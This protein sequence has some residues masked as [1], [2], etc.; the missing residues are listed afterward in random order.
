M[1]NF[2]KFFFLQHNTLETEG[3]YIW[4]KLIQLAC[5]IR[6]N[7]QHQLG[8][9]SDTVNYLPSFS[10][11][12]QFTMLSTVSLHIGDITKLK[13]DAIVSSANETLQSTYGGKG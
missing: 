8:S 2:I 11:S 4:S 9:D 7:L 6:H 5:L 12:K 1:L 10:S 3:T 13:V